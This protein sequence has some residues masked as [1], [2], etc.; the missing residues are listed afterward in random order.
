MLNCGVTPVGRSGG[1][2]LLGFSPCIKS[3]SGA[4]IFRGFSYNPAEIN[5]AISQVQI[6]SIMEKL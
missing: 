5:Y 4:R 6:M 2:M 3:E 1:S